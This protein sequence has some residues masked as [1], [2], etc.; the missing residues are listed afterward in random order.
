MPIG[1]KFSTN[2]VKQIWTITYFTSVLFQS[3]MVFGPFKTKVN[4]DDYLLD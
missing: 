1:K 2:L 3:E 4:A